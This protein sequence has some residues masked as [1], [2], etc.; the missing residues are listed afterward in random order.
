MIIPVPYTYCTLYCVILTSSVLRT[1]FF[2]FFTWIFIVYRVLALF[3]AKVLERRNGKSQ[4]LVRLLEIWYEIYLLCL[5]TCRQR[6]INDE[7]IHRPTSSPCCLPQS[8]CWMRRAAVLESG[9][10]SMI[11]VVLFILADIAGFP[12]RI[13]LL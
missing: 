3:S 4:R 13:K 5:S 2:H 8:C 12:I 10:L 11:N 6:C 7:H 9:S 1:C